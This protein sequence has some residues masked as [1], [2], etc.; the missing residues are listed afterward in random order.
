MAKFDFNLACDAYN[1]NNYKNIS[2]EDIKFEMTKESN[3]EILID[4]VSMFKRLSI[5]AQDL[6]RTIFECPVEF[7]SIACT[8]I[9]KKI[10]KTGVEKYSKSIHGKKKGIRIFKEVRKFVRQTN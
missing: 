5:E 6:I 4:K 8:P 7:L 9:E 10:C 2:D 1:I 3:I